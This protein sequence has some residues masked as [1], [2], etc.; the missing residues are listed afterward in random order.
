[1]IGQCVDSLKNLMQTMETVVEIQLDCLSLEM[2]ILCA[3]NANKV[4][5]CDFFRAVHCMQAN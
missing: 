5:A 4:S 2:I 3:S 1:M